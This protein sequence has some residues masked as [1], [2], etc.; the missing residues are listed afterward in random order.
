MVY[1]NRS[2][3][4]FLSAEGLCFFETPV[5]TC[6]LPAG[7]EGSEAGGEGDAVGALRPRGAAEVAAAHARGGSSVLQHQ[8]AECRVPAVRRQRRGELLFGGAGKRRIRS[9]PP[10]FSAGIS[11]RSDS[12]IFALYKFE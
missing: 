11:S 8:E 4:R 1:W 7:A 2:F 12:S 3:E 5:V 6:H 10:S 9:A